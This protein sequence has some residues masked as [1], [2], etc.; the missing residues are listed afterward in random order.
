MLQGSCFQTLSTPEK[1]TKET[2]A[3]LGFTEWNT[4]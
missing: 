2:Q 1:S 4:Y 3:E